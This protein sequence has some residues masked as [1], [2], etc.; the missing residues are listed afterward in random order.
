MN[1]R[2]EVMELIAG[3][4]LEK[5]LGG[6]ERF[7]IELA[8]RVDREQFALSVFGLWCFEPVLKQR[9]IRL[10]NEAGVSTYEG[11]DWDEFRPYRAFAR[12]YRHLAKTLRDRP[13][14][15][16][17]SHDQFGDVMAVMLK[18]AHPRMKIV[19]TTHNEREWKKRPLRRIFLRGLLYPLAYDA[20]VALNPKMVADLDSRLAARVW[21]RRARCIGNALNLDRFA[22]SPGSA[23]EV[24]REL[25]IA[26][27]AVVIGSIGRL[28]EQKGY[29]IF[30]QAAARVLNEKPGTSFIITGSGELEEALKHQAS[31]LGVVEQVIF[32]GARPDVERLLGAFDLFVSSSLWEGLPTVIMESMAAGVPVLA[33]RI[34][35]T[36]DLITDGETGLLAAPGDPEALAGRI[37]FALDHPELRA[38]LAGRARKAVEKFSIGSAAAQYEALFLDL[39]GGRQA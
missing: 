15:I 29:S 7:V 3:F 6:I 39:A 30:L 25:G 27:S 17:H 19:R 10:L 36:V 5:P 37:L 23:E 24:K 21:R 4:S 11:S 2:V 31:N 8:R 14:D 13:V 12:S 35:G 28:S 38:E 1:R 20:E 26:P 34:P 18:L 33:T 22:R 9:W 16:L 32:T